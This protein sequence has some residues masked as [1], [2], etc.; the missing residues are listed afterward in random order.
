MKTFQQMSDDYAQIMHGY[1]E[2]ILFQSGNNINPHIY[3]E[4]FS[5]FDKSLKSKSA[6]SLI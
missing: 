1:S 6:T 3:Y 2:N 4:E 5:V